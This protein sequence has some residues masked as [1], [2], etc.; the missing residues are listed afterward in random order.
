MLH[1]VDRRRP[2]PWVPEADGR[3]LMVTVHY[4]AARRAPQGRPT[5]YATEDESRLLLRGVGVE[6]PASV[7]EVARMRT[8]GAVDVRPAPGR[9]PLVVLSPGFGVPRFTLTHL[10]EDLAYESSGTAVPDGRILTCV[11]WKALEEGRVPGAVP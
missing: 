8:Y 6:D 2:D 9:H 4:P 10:A 7:R 1:L 5:P 11:A 3:E